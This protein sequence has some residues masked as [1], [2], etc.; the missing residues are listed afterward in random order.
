MK[1]AESHGI[2]KAPREGRNLAS[3]DG[4][5]AIQSLPHN[6]DDFCLTKVNFPKQRQ[7]G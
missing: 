7:S 2:L 6:I 1:I 3:P 5:D 4:L